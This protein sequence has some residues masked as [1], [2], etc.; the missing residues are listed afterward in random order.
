[1]R[2]GLSGR[3][4][5]SSAL[6]RMGPA[7]GARLGAGS[8]APGARRVYSAGHRPN[9]NHAWWLTQSGYSSVIAS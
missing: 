7:V 8:R 9:I 2:T 6:E 1:M 4:R 3:S 5:K